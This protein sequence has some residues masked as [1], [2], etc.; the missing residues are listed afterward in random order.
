MDGPPEMAVRILLEKLRLGFRSSRQRER[1]FRYDVDET[2]YRLEGEFRRDPLTALAGIRRFFSDRP[3][4][5]LIIPGGDDW[6]LDSYLSS[7]E[8]LRDLVEIRSEDPGL[9]LQLDGVQESFDLNDVFPAFKTALAASTEW[10]GILLWTQHVE[11]TFLPLPQGR[12]QLAEAAHW[13]FSHLATSLGLD[14]ELFARQYALEFP[15]VAHRRRDLIRLLHL[16]DLH[17]G[18][19]E[20]DKRLPRVM[21]L[22][23]NLAAELD[24]G[25]TLVPVVTGDLIDDP[26]DKNVDKL[27]PFIQFLSDLGDTQPLVVLGN[28]DV[29]SSGLVGENFRLAAQMPPTPVAWLSDDRVGIV[30]FNSVAGGRLARGHLG[31]EQLQDLG[32]LID[33]H[34]EWRESILVGLIHHHPTPV[35]LPEWYGRRPFY[36]RLLGGTFERTLELEDADSFLGFCQVRGLTA[37]L[38]GHKHIPRVES[39]YPSGVTIFGCGSSVGKVPTN[40]ARTYMSMNL[41]SIDPNRRK[42]VGRCLAERVPGGG[43]AEEKRHELV[44]RTPARALGSF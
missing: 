24:D 7:E 37:V 23:R 21:Q 34:R 32:T 26:E 16:S 44:T 42:I 20:A 22:V 9:I 3:W 29:R 27:R 4:T 2:L 36:E 6:E 18:S 13:V 33:Q 30:S 28:H 38:H 19:K 43:L 12:R 8:F 40:D 31:E 5:A 1:E 25:S 14:L 10:P 41:V 39:H 17:V 15:D 35:D 11:S